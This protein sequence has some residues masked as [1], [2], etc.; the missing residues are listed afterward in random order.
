MDHVWGYATDQRLRERNE[1]SLGVFELPSC[2]LVIVCDG[3][4]GHA[5][6]D[7]ASAI[8]V[9]VIHDTLREHDNLPLE[10]ALSD[11]VQTAN[12]TI[13]DVSRKVRRLL[14]M[15]TTVAAIAVRGSQAWIAHVG[16]S[17]V[18]RVRG[19]NAE[20]LTRDHTMVNLFVDAELLSAEDAH[21]HPEAH[22]L[23]R[24]VGVD[25][26]VDVDVAGPIDL[27]SGDILFACSDGVHGSID[28]DEFADADW[29]TP[30]IGV[31]Q[32]LKV[33]RAREGDDNATVAAIGVG[34]S[35]LRC[36][37]PSMLPAPEVLASIG[38]GTEETGLTHGIATPVPQAPRPAIRMP[39]RGSGAFVLDGGT[40]VRETETIRFT[41]SNQ[42]PQ[43]PQLGVPKPD[44]RPDV[45]APATTN[46]EA[47]TSRLPL[48]LGVAAAAA[49]VV[50]TGAWL[51]NR[52]VSDP[53]A[54]AAPE[55]SVQV[56]TGSPED[57]GVEPLPEDLVTIDLDTESSRAMALPD[58]WRFAPV[59]PARNRRMPHRAGRYVEPPPGGSLQL[60]AV[61]AARNRECPQA[62]D[63]VAAG[64]RVSTDFAALYSDAWECFTD[65][66]QSVL[67]RQ[68]ARS[69]DQFGDLLIHFEG[70]G[71][72]DP[73]QRQL[74][75]WARPAQAGI[76][77]RLDAFMRSNDDDRLADVMMDRLG[78]P[79]LAES[80]V[81]DATLEVHAARALSRIEE[82]SDDV[83][84]WWARRAYYASRFLSG[85][86]GE[87]IAQ[88]RPDEREALIEALDEATGGL[89]TNPQRDAANVPAPVAAAMRVASGQQAAPVVQPT[90]PS[91]RPA[92]AAP[93]PRPAPTVEAD[94]E[95]PADPDARPIV[96]RGGEN[97][98]PEEFR[99]P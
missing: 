86:P 91:P 73:V 96:H 53:H 27:R 37:P 6:G 5:G 72:T 21:S 98:M 94:T 30:Q 69:L 80:F 11:A 66:N 22:I 59:M 44:I 62:L 47:P 13:Y 78:G 85:L 71:A 28:D 36:P 34:F 76:E 70:H 89:Y 52:S 24:S 90:A 46:A 31:E 42:R 87:L 65:A 51:A 14:G 25:R 17:R 79:G 45:E 48:L 54:A 29:T 4:G 18:Y 88:Y 10:Q 57:P 97:P 75:G 67:A 38:M 68:D 12:R 7:Q 50:L 33:V 41:P 60:E 23:A 26:H 92:T 9:R 8:A 1:D 83:T 95:A 61:L 56:L 2:T 39:H 82:P 58:E 99:N 20:L 55:A 93:Q 77:Y 32:L 15:G 64:M 63:A 81:R 3:M 49:A 19:R 40:P 35:T 16:D 84:R 43:T 74:A